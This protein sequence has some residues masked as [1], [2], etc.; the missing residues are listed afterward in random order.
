[1]ADASD[2][3]SD[4]GD[5]VWVQVPSPACMYRIARSLSEDSV[6]AFF[7]GRRK[8]CRDRCLAI[9]EPIRYNGIKMQMAGAEVMNCKET[10]RLL[11]P[12][13]N[14][15]LEEKEEEN[16]VKHVRHCP[17]CYEELEV[18]ATVFAGIRQLDG[19]EE[20]IDY[21]TLV[22]DSLETSEEDVIDEHFLGTYTFLL[23]TAAT[24]VLFYMMVRCFF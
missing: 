20:K 19:A 23:R 24:M 8:N 7:M 10:Q 21:R 9:P 2:S 22:E 5:Y 12:Y 4:V 18:Y 6:L 17:E 11:V 3:K 15:E 14:G 13:I 16:F 1:M